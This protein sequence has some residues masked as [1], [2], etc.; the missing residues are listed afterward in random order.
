[1]IITK[2]KRKFTSFFGTLFVSF[3]LIVCSFICDDDNQ[4][5]HSFN[6]IVH[7]FVCLIGSINWLHFLIGL[8]QQIDISLRLMRDVVLTDTQGCFEET[9]NLHFAESKVLHLRLKTCTMIGIL[10]LT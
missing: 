7:L 3:A 9:T 2:D 8:L 1:V 10:A 5:C 4:S 6:T